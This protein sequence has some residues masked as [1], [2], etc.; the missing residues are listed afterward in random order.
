MIN[1]FTH[2]I[3]NQINGKE[4]LGTVKHEQTNVNAIKKQNKNC[5]TLNVVR[6]E[7]TKQV[8]SLATDLYFSTQTQSNNNMFTNEYVIYYI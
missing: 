7:C 1:L 6:I 8:L 5:T 4:L 3:I 2:F